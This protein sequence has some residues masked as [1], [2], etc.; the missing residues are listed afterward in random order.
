MR[1]RR[2]DISILMIAGLASIMRV[3]TQFITSGEDNETLCGDRECVV[4]NKCPAVLKLVFKV[5]SGDPEARVQLL[6]SQCGFE[7]S[8]PKVCCDRGKPVDATEK[9]RIFQNSNTVPP[10]FTE[11]T[12]TDPTPFTTSTTTTVT[13]SPPPVSVSTRS[14]FSSLNSDTCGT[15]T[16]LTF[17]ITLGEDA[18]AGQFPWLGSLIYRDSRGNAVPLC[19]ASLISSQHLLTAAH[20]DASQQGF[21]LSSVRLGQVDLSAPVSLPGL[22][23]NVVDIVSHPSYTNRPVAIFDIA[24]VKMER[25]VSFTDMIRPICVFQEEDEEVEE[26]MRELVVAGWGRT[27]RSRSSSVLQF[28]HLTEVEREECED[29]YRQAAGVGRLGPLTSGLSILPSQICA[30]GEAGT[31]SCS[32]DSG[33]P[34]MALDSKARW[35]LTGV[36]SFGTNECDS[37]LPGVYTKISFFYEWILQTLR[38]N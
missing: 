15:R 22:E 10:T 20:C 31:D 32:G 38:N 35:H 29:E 21:R 27:E 2:G 16:A 30:R 33:G 37:S 24:L 19:G 6:K 26:E 3:R 9:P 36:V 17:R 12:E 34:L 4:I 23:L 11:Q 8:L 25:P 28:T 5:K 1:S 7:K 18:V 14:N 13:P